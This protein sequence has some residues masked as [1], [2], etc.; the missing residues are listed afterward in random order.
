MAKPEGPKYYCTPKDCA[1]FLN[2]SKKTFERRGLVEKVI[3][4]DEVRSLWNR[5]DKKWA[6]RKPHDSEQRF[7]ILRILSCI[8]RYGFQIRARRGPLM[9]IVAK[10]HI[11]C[12]LKFLQHMARFH[13]SNQTEQSNMQKLFKRWF[14]ISI[15]LSDGIRMGLSNSN[16]ATTSI[17][18]PRVVCAFRH[19]II[20]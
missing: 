10:W 2:L 13:T 14:S 4:G 17:G 5:L 20:H 8:L 3:T 1:K 11:L 7:P 16:C 9:A 19:V 12:R 6:S 18:E 15:M